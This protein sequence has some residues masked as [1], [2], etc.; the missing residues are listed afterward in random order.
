VRRTRT[1]R[2][3]LVAAIALAALALGLSFVAGEYA[4]AALLSLGLAAPLIGRAG[5]VALGVLGAL[6]LAGMFAIGAALGDAEA[7]GAELVAATLA[8]AGAA[9]AGGATTGLLAQ[10]KED[11]EVENARLRDTLTGLVK[12]VHEAE[13]R[14]R[15]RIAREL[16]DGA[17]QTLLFVN[18]DLI[19]EAE[20]H[21]AIGRVQQV[22]VE[23]LAEMRRAVSDLHPATAAHGDLGASVQALADRAA[24]RG[25]F[26]VEVRV[27]PAASSEHDQ[28]VV[29]IVRELLT[30]AAKH[31]NASRVGVV[32]RL[33]S[34]Q[35]EATV[36]D[37]GTGAFAR[38][39][40]YL[41]TEGGVGLA[42]I[43]ERVRAVGG[44]LDLDTPVGGGTLARARIPVRTADRT[45]AGR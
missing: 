34:G 40:T 43:H 11:Q 6:A 36:L 13:D 30:N 23:I 27:D 14:E 25:R 31:A 35:V 39:R 3:L 29:G 24:E 26:D 32:V 37:D 5:G 38:P 8:F 19:D 21:P 15:E 28:L 2:P 22:V 33:K 12:Q 10:A 16:H 18:Q 45:G 17:M 44:E 42:A 9:L 4:L 7:G 41:P 20:R 1:D